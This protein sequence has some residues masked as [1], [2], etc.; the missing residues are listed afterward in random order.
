MK[1][2]DRVLVVDDVI[3]SG[4]S[5]IEAIQKRREAGL[6]VVKA[7][8]M[9]DRQEQNGRQNIESEGILVDALCTLEDLQRIAPRTGSGASWLASP[10]GNWLE[11]SSARPPS[12][13]SFYIHGPSLALTST[14]QRWPSYA[15]PDRRYPNGGALGSSRTA[16]RSKYAK[17]AA[18]ACSP[19]SAACPACAT[20]LRAAISPS[21]QARVATAVPKGSVSGER[22]IEPDAVAKFYKAWS[23]RLAW[24]HRAVPKIVKAIRGIEEDT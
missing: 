21:I 18:S 11:V 9:I 22:L 15:Q 6:T 20:G 5:T 19:Y 13:L 4:K 7:V 17:D 16:P 23:S 12:R 3:T 24:D 1:A 10:P 14:C 2:G 8:A